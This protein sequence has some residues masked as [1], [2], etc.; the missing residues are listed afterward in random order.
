MSFHLVHIY[1][2][3]HKV[4]LHTVYGYVSSHSHVILFTS[5][6]IVAWERKAHPSLFLLSLFNLLQHK[7]QSFF[8]SLGYLKPEPLHADAGGPGV[9]IIGD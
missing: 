3:A 2:H 8:S 9:S 4:Y 1:A 6:S 5:E 7:K